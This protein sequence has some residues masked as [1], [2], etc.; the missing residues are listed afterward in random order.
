MTKFVK[1]GG[2]LI[3]ATTIQAV[4]IN[5]LVDGI[6][7]VYFNPDSSGRC[8]PSQSVGGIEAID[9]VMTLKPSALEGVR[10][11]WLRRAWMV[12]NLIGHPAMQL[13]ALFKQYDWAM[14][15]HEATI[16]RPKS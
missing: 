4:D 2:A 13:L 10:L 7:H 15:I 16:P 6:V 14:R 8:R 1:I 5:D 9:L 3:S 12:H 11:K